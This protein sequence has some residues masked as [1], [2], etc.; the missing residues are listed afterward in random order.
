MII[1]IVHIP[2]VSVLEFEPYEIVA[3]DPD[4]PIGLQ[5]TFELV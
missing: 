3:C 1:S 4:G 2:H 5:L